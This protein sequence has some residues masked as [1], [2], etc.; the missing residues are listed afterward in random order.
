MARGRGLDAVEVLSHLA[1]PVFTKRGG[2]DDVL[3]GPVQASGDAVA[4][5][6]AR[7]AGVAQ[8]D[9]DD[10]LQAQ[11]RELLEALIVGEGREGGNGRVEA[12]GML[13]A[14]GVGSS[15]GGS[16]RRLSGTLTW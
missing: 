1:R 8:R 10:V 12:L 9:L 3:V 14:A 7:A 15:R 5:S 11:H 13:A 4:V 2:E 16:R 6:V